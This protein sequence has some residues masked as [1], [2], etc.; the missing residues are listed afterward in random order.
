ML[1][2]LIKFDLITSPVFYSISNLGIRIVLNMAK[3]KNPEMNLFCRVGIHK[4]SYTN[5]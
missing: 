4:T 3:D 2:D 1:V 5:L